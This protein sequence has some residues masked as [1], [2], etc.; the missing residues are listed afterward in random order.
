LYF[1]F[2]FLYFGFALHFRFDFHLYFGLWVF[3]WEAYSGFLVGFGGFVRLGCFR[4]R[5]ECLMVVF[6]FSVF[7]ALGVIGALCGYQILGLILVGLF[8]FFFLRASYDCFCVYS[9][10]T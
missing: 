2:A 3:F 4:G 6:F 1:G 9:R 10:Y 8:G 7:W 5:F